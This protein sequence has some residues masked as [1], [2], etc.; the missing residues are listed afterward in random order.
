M[1]KGKDRKTVMRT[2]IL[3]AA[4]CLILSDCMRSLAACQ[5]EDPFSTA[6]T[7]A[8]GDF[9]VGPG[10]DHGGNDGIFTED[11]GTADLDALFASIQ[12]MEASWQAAQSE[13]MERAGIPAERQSFVHAEG[14]QDASRQILAMTA[15]YRG[16]TFYNRIVCQWYAENLWKETYTYQVVGTKYQEKAVEKLLSLAAGAADLLGNGSAVLTEAVENTETALD[17]QYR[18]TVILKNR[19]REEIYDTDYCQFRIPVEWD[20]WTEERRRECEELLTM[21]EEDFREEIKKRQSESLLWSPLPFYKQGAIEW[22]AEPFG[23]GTL[24]SDACCPTAIAMVLSYFEGRRITPS[25]VAAR[26]DNDACRSRSQGSYGGKMCAAAAADYGLS[27]EAGVDSLTGKQIREALE[28]GAK[29]VMSMKPGG[30]GG[31]YAH[32]YHYVTLAGLTQDGK[33][34]VNNP[35]INTDVTYDD[36]ETILDNQSGRGYGIF[37]AE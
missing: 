6:G 28:S 15:V 29:I 7:A 8:V 24:A 17:G 16:Y 11:I 3:L 9:L 30:T 34:I 4:V 31:R 20:G 35:G 22:G 37:R 13:K 36:M 10:C 18:V 2:G 19:P 32:V 5:A 23:D 14:F 25:E 26:Y 27:V 1:Q 21:G 12:G 33:V